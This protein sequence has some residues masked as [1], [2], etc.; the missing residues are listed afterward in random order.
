MGEGGIGSDFWAL[1]QDSNQF[2]TNKLIFLYL[3]WHKQ[4]TKKE[5]APLIKIFLSDRFKDKLIALK[6]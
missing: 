2:V 5:L 6:H 1:Q 4:V 3:L